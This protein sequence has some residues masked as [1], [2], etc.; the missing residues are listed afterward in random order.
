ML[1]DLPSPERSP[2]FA[3]AGTGFEKAGATE[4]ALRWFGVPARDLNIWWV[5]AAPLIERALARG[6]GEMT[7]EDVR[8]FLERRAMQLWLL[9]DGARVCGALATELANYPRKRSC[10]LRLFAAD[11]GWRAAWLRLLPLI[12][13]W[14]REQGCAAVE[15][16]GRPGWARILGYD[17]KQVVLSKELQE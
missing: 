14:A 15:V 13:P 8:G 1:A 16:F 5:S 17:I 4:G 12:E 6:R 2:G 10:I 7:A 3:Q 11:A 9:W